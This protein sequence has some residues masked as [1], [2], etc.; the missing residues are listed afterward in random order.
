VASTDSSSINSEANDFQVDGP[1]IACKGFFD[2][3]AGL[4][5]MAETVIIG[6]PDSTARRWG[7]SL[8]NSKNSTKRLDIFVDRKDKT[9]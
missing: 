9:Q 2:D 3:I 6:F 7:V 1:P 8:I 4:L 5:R